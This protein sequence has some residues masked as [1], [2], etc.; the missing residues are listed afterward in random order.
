MNLNFDDFQKQDIKFDIDKLKN[1]YQEILKI[2]DFSGPEGV[3]NF[4]AIS[5]TQIP[6]DPD[7]I[8]GNKARGVFWTKPDGSGKEVV[9]D[10]KINEAAYSEFIEEYKN[11][12]F[13]EVFDVLSTK[14]KLGRVRILLKQPRSC[15]LYTSP[16]PRDRS[17][18]RM[19]SSA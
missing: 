8:K 7:S 6:G 2:K 1:A 14:Y 16:S 3:S 18:S 4:G 9:R 17:L 5:L 10:E 13:K 15:L 11:T 12:Y 19:P